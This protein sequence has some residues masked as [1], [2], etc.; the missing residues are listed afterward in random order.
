MRFGSM[1]LK[2]HSGLVQP[3]HGAHVHRV[4]FRLPEAQGITPQVVVVLNAVGIPSKR[5]NYLD[6]A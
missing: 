4:R 3:H 6:K 2:L 1:N 5:Q